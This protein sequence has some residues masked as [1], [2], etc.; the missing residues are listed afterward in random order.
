MVAGPTPARVEHYLR[1]FEVLSDEEWCIEE[2]LV[3]MVVRPHGG[4]LTVDEVVRRLHGDPTAM[5]TC[6]PADVRW[7]DDLIYVEQR[8]D[9]VMVL[10]YAA[11]SAEEN[12]LKRLSR[13]ATVHGVYWAIN[14]ANR[15]FHAVDGV[16][17]TELDTLRPR[18]RW[19]ADPE[20]LS[21]HLGALLEMHDPARP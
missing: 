10:E 19:G 2:S 13:G 5:T 15:L 4:A 12:A 20:A 6:R 17:V 16:I 8:D 14:N 18:D 11:Y 3:W 9:A 21:D 7:E 1:M